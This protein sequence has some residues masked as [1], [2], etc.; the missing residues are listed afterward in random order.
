MNMLADAAAGDP[1]LTK[2][3]LT[4]NS[5]AQLSHVA[6]LPSVAYARPET[7]VAMLSEY[8]RPAVSFLNFLLLMHIADY[9]LVGKAQSR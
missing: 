8:V 5:V 4:S 2:N 1:L 9:C 3:E 6:L 7:F